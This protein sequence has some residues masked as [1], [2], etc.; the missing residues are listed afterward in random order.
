[1][2]KFVVVAESDLM[3]AEFGTNDIEEACEMYEQFCSDNNF[4]S[5]NLYDGETGEVYAYKTIVHSPDG[6]TITQWVA[7]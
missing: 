3:D 1:M 7:K 2:T 6:I 4:F 5:V